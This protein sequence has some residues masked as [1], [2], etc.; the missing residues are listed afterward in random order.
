[1]KSPVQVILGCESEELTTQ[2][3]KLPLTTW[4]RFARS[5][6]KVMVVDDVPAYRTVVMQTLLPD[7]IRGTSV[8]PLDSSIVTQ[9]LQAESI[10]WAQAHSVRPLEFM[11]ETNVSSLTKWCMLI[12]YFPGPLRTFWQLK[13]G[14]TV[15]QA[16]LPW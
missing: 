12:A 4:Q 2:I 8:D 5:T 7:N 11:H 9:W 13:W 3:L 10:Q 16:R 15:Q 14:D 6:P 1:M